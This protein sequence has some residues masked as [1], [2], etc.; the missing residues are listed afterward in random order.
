MRATA[1]QPPSP[2][3]LP[4][5][6]RCVVMLAACLLAASIL[7]CAPS[8][9]QAAPDTITGTCFVECTNAHV[10]GA[11]GGNEF[12]VSFPQYGLK[13]VGYCTSGALYGTPL[14]GNYPFTGVREDGGGYRIS[15]DCSGAGMYPNHFSPNGPQNVGA[16]SIYPFGR[17]GVAKSSAAPDVTQGS[18]CYSLE[19]AVYG[20]Y[21]DEACTM[22]AGTVVTGPDGYGEC[23]DSLA[24]GRYWVREDSPPAGYAADAGVHPVRVEAG[25]R[26]GAPVPVIHVQDVPVLAPAD[27]AVRKVD[28][29]TGLAVPAG[30]GSL[31]GAVFSI[32]HYDGFFQSVD[33]I[34]DAGARPRNTWSAETDED[35]RA[36]LDAALLPSNGMGTGIPR[37]TVVVRETAAPRGYL[38]T[39]QTF[40]V[41]IGA[42]GDAGAT[43]A[44]AV[45]TVREQAVAGDLALVKF[46]EPAG[47]TGEA[48][49]KQPLAGVA[50]DIVLASTGALAARVVTDADGCASTEALRVEGASGALPFGRYLVREDPETVPAGYAPAPEFEA[51]V[52]EDGCRLFYVVEDSTGTA[53]RIVKRDAETGLPVAGTTRF[54]ILDENGNAVSFV[55]RYPGNVELTEFATD[56]LGSCVLPEKLNGGT[57]YFVQET[58]APPGY[59]LDGTPIP[60]EL[61][62]DGT[63]AGFDDPLTVY[64]D[65]LPQKGRLVV[66]KTDAAT[67]APVAA[68][69]TAWEIRAAADVATPD[70]TLRARAGEVVGILE[71]DA[72]GRASSDQLYLGSYELAETKA[73]PGYA[74]AEAPLAVELA[75]GDQTLAVVEQRIAFADDPLPQAPEQDGPDRPALAS[76]GSPSTTATGAALA[77]AV[78]GVVLALLARNRAA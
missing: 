73:P 22:R 45:P 18:P 3:P 70:G 4:A 36:F 9:A 30:D 71:T 51:V 6:R 32:E 55:S 34:A 43:A 65:D 37:G 10:D 69:G 50:F 58:Q 52:A 25:D 66:D 48:A 8:Q 57:R 72:Q 74:C 41:R 12:C 20:I 54:R 7:A 19:G 61:A 1:L 31:A 33:Q 49:L 64:L 47:S 11:A 16:F 56:G 63:G 75:P 39:D 42:E 67:G 44:F 46:G 21:S 14:P 15:I 2:H 35:G 77:A 78:A 26:P 28:A 38:P 40:V 68:A 5:A 27:V 62:A 17:I 76:T 59:V 60:F 29:A 53:L 24:A 23:D 13:T